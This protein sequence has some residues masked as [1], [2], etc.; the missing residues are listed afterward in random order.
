MYYHF[1][2]S[3]FIG[4]VCQIEDLRFVIGGRHLHLVSAS[5]QVL[6]A[7]V[8]PLL[9]CLKS[10]TAIIN[11]TLGTGLRLAL[12]KT[13]NEVANDIG[14]R[15]DLVTRWKREHMKYGNNSFARNGNVVMTDQ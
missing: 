10:S 6:N 9:L 15:T 7:P 5:F 1:K 13:T 8:V 4:I 3:G 14:L 2:L 11:C 12:F